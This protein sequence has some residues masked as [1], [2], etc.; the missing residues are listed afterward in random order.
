MEVG[1]AKYSGR[2]LAV[3][4]FGAALI[5]TYWPTLS[6]L[7]KV[8]ATDPHSSHGFLVPV[9]SGV[10]LWARRA[11]LAA[12]DLRPS[13]LG[14]PLLVAAGVMH[15]VGGYYYSPWLDQ[16]SFILALLGLCLALGGTKAFRLAG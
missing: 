9:F 6:A 12:L 13:W 15:S 8:W 4:G 3:V 14:L 7:V 1:R 5:W 10:M 16:M 2:L 11:E